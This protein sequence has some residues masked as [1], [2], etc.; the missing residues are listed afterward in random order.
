MMMTVMMSMTQIVEWGP[1]GMIDFLEKTQNFFCLF[2]TL[3]FILISSL[4]PPLSSP[5]FKEVSMAYEVLGDENKRK[6]YDRYGLMGLQMYSNYASAG[7]MGQI[8]FNPNLMCLVF[9]ACSFVVSLAILF[10]AF[11]SVKIDGLV[12]WNWAA[13]FAPLWVLDIFVIAF[14]LYNAFSLE[15]PEEHHDDDDE[16]Q[17]AP[18]KRNIL[19]GLYLLSKFLLFTLWQIFIVG[20]LSSWEAL[21]WTW[22]KVWIPIFVLEGLFFIEL[23][24]EYRQVLA[25]AAQNPDSQLTFGMRILIF[26]H[27]FR[28]WL[29]RALQSVFIAI[30]A[31]E[32]VVWNWGVVAIPF[33][34][35]VLLAIFVDYVY[36][37]RLMKMAQSQEQK[38][39]IKSS[40]CMKTIFNLIFLT[41]ILA[42]VGMLVV[43]LNSGE[44]TAAVILTPIFIIL[45]I[46]L[47][48]CCCC[49]PLLYCCSGPGGAGD[50]I[51]AGLRA[52]VSLTLPLLEPGP[53][54]TP[55]WTI[56]NQ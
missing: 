42:F 6:I 17:Q 27:I 44:R 13:V 8:L 34:V 50:D 9:L 48:C 41:L 31:D 23:A 25:L 32:I 33:F 38:G 21:G 52:Q 19:G 45:G 39:E 49:I 29:F 47:C 55:K 18:P 7:P 46:I 26:F 11:L 37:S 30:R 28:W 51:E 2:F 5:Q 54:N 4:F 40:I 20:M 14:L 15:A 24:I 3:L 16:I 1:C 22:V 43:H 53:G 12:M 10:P 36:T 35:G 56:D